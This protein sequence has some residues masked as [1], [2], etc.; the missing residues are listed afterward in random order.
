[1]RLARTAI[2]YVGLLASVLISHLVGRGSFIAA[3]AIVALSL[4]IITALSISMPQELEGPHLALLV[5]ITQTLGHFI[6]GGGSTDSSMTI[7]HLVGGFTG[8]QTVRRVD[9]IVCKL[10]SLVQYALLPLSISS[11][12]FPINLPTVSI[13]TYI[14]HTLKRVSSCSSLLAA[15]STFLSSQLNRTVNHR[16]G[17]LY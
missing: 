2:A 7:S 12:A 13:S 14:H 5:L 1:M 9:Q 3:P 15:R 10:E 16:G 6:L 11:L 8:Y 4:L 17:L